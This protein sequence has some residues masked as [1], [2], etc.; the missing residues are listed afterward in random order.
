MRA[1]V[2]PAAGLEI[3]ERQAEQMMK[4][5]PAQFDVDPV[6]GVVERVGPQELQDGFEQAERH[7]AEHEHDQG[8]HALVNQHLVDDKLEEDW[9]RERENL[10]EQ[11]GD[12]HVG[13]RAPVAQNRGEEPAE[14]ERVGI[15]A[16]SAEPAR[17]QDE[18]A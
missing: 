1:T 18:F 3:S 4:Q 17:D 2:C 9:R 13:E 8:R 7:H 11:R 6:G 16:R 12:E 14:A 10:H 15:G 5:A